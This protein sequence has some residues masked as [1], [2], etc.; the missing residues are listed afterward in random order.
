MVSI[1]SV[2]REIGIQFVPENNIF[3]SLKMTARIIFSLKP[4]KQNSSNQLN[5]TFV[6]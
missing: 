4:L 2:I 5:P 1:G 3:F 6:S